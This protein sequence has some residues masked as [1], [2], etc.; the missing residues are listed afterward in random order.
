MKFRRFSE[1]LIIVAL[2]AAIYAPPIQLA[3]QDQFSSGSAV[4]PLNTGWGGTSFFVTQAKNMGYQV[5]YSNSTIDD[6]MKVKGKMLYIIMGPDLALTDQEQ[7]LI[8]SKMLS[9]DLSLLV[10]QGNR[11]NNKFLSSVFGITIT[12]NPI[13]DPNSPFQD[14]RVMFAA[15]HLNGTYQIEINVASPIVQDRKMTNGFS[16]EPIGFTGAKSYDTGNNKVGARVVATAINRNGVANGVVFSDSGVFI[17]SVLN[18]TENRDEQRLA[19]NVIDLLTEGNRETTIL[20]DNSHYERN[21]TVLPFNIPPIGMLVAVFLTSYLETFNQTY[22]QFLATTPIPLLLLIGISTVVGTYFGL[23]RWM[24]RQPIGK[25][26]PKIPVIESSRL[27]ENSSKMALANMKTNGRFYL[28][29]LTKLYYVLDDLVKREFGASLEQI[30]FDEDDWQISDRIGWD[31]QQRLV[32]IA[33]DLSKIRDK[34]E[35]RRRFIFPP[36]LSWK[37][38][39]SQITV[40]TDKVLKV[41]GTYLVESEGKEV[42]GIEYKLRKR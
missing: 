15:V 36:I 33:R 31:N 19:V 41:I 8:E 1:L 16:V 7:T 35:G 38:K 40:E 3:A 17:N 13:I 29:T 25:D 5:V 2:V 24:G 37:R 39:F 6:V 18:S 30:G 42:R 9:N 28:D 21:G 22:D 27:I 23:K 12:G 14:K 20:I 4:R 11:T 34:A 26:T 32:K 10:A